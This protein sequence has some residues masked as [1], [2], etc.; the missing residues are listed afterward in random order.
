MNNFIKVNTVNDWDQIQ[1]S[2]NTV[3]DWDEDTVGP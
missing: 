3:N 2:L 1:W